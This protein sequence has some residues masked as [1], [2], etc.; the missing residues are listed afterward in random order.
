MSVHPGIVFYV[1]GSGR[2]GSTL[3]G[4]I[5]G[6]LPGYICVGEMVF[7]WTRGLI[8]D[9]LC[10]CG[11][12]FSACPFWVMVGER[13]F[14]GW[15]A[16]DAPAVE[17]LHRSVDRHRYLP[18]MLGPRATSYGHRLDEYTQLLTRVYAAVRE[19]SGAEVVVDTSKHPSY[20]Y[21]LRRTRGVE[22][23]LLHLVRD[24]RGV[25]HSWTRE[26]A[27]PEVRGAGA[28]MPTYSSVRAAS[29]WAIH[30]LLF[31]ILAKLR[32]SHRTVRYEDFVAHPL[33]IVNAVNDDLVGRGGQLAEGC[34]TLKGVDLPADHSLSG[35]PMRFREG[36]IP[37][38][39]DDEWRTKMPAG[40]RRLVTALTVLGLR[41]Y[42]YALS[43]DKPR[44]SLSL[45]ADGRVKDPGPS[46]V[47]G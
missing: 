39:A 26:V 31:E 44:R 17:A 29:E 21:V 24:S 2:S 11:E 15:D 8:D 19:V 4:R 27:R 30:N 7:I 1:G 13:A 28:K 47:R 22:L 10:G 9:E 14:G 37:L 25:S 38:K 20:A 36:R 46:P 18:L 33:E 6:R 34:I 35:N 23:R 45:R 16:V 5:F 42:R 32:V 40:A 41:R 3:I 12:P 43:P